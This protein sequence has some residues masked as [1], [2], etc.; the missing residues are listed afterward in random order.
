ML[1]KLKSGDIFL[2]KQENIKYF[3]NYMGS[4]LQAYAKELTGP[5]LEWFKAVYGTSY[6]LLLKIIL[7]NPLGFLD[8]Y[9]NVQ[10]FNGLKSEYIFGFPYLGNGWIMVSEKTGVHIYRLG[11]Q[12]IQYFDIYR[13]NGK[14][15]EEAMKQELLTFWNL[16]YDY[17]NSLLNGFSSIIDIISK[18]ETIMDSEKINIQVGFFKIINNLISVNSIG[19]IGNIELIIRQYKLL[20]IDV[21]RNK[22]IDKSTIPDIISSFSPLI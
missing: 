9:F 5:F 18:N 12:A 22:N 7:S 1:E 3:F 6:Y 4:D 17:Q 21:S 10:L 15:D 2:V 14:Y 20:N 11:L 13:Y 16:P 8:D 19:Y